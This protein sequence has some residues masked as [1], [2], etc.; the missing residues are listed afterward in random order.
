MIIMALDHTRDFFHQYSHLYEPNDLSHTSPAIFFTRWITHLCA[1]VFVF[2][3][4]TSA[5][6]QGQ[7]KSKRELSVFLIKR[8]LWLIVLELTLVTFGW[9]FN[10]YFSLVLL[11]VIWVLGISMV[12]LAALLHLP[13]TLLFVLGILMVAS[14]HLLDNVHVTGNNLEAFLW[15]ILHEF[16]AFQ[17]RGV[18]VYTAYPIIP[19]VGV[20]AL[21]YCFGSLYVNEFD[22][23]KRK[24]I[25]F[26]LGCIG[27]VLFLV[28]RYSNVYGDPSKWSG[29]PTT[30]FSILSF[31]NTTKYPPSLLFLLMTLSPAMFLLL[32]A[33]RGTSKFANI[34][35]TYGRV[36][37][38]YYLVHIY[39]LHLLAMIAAETTGFSW[40]DMIFTN[41][42][43]TQNLDLVGYGFNLLTVYVIWLSMV[44]VM[45]PLCRYYDAFKQSHR[46]QWWLSYL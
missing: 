40:K 1:P 24:K 45:Y 26:F 41:T 14:H 37:L 2:L 6:L 19:W 12:L 5:F 7:K 17:F 13:R 23:Q 28:I 9:F 10:P 46:Q 35:A 33:E 11:Q 4:G 18:T 31:L 43:I 27:I 3:A 21:G 36:P 42:W 32:L 20:M 39:L 15:S 44:I 34:I 8:G 16:N 22:A 30:T 29:M 38:F 25:L